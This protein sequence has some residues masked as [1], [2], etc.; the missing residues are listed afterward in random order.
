MTKFTG[1]IHPAA[2]MFPLL[3][4]KAFEEFCDDIEK[5][6]LSKPIEL[7]P[8]GRLIDGRNRLRACQEIR[9]E[10]EF[11]TVNPESP[12]AY[13][14]S[15]N[16]HRRHL[17]SSQLAALAVEELPRL[18][19]QAKERQRKGKKKVADPSEVGQSRH[20]AAKLFNTNSH[21]VESAERIKRDAPD[22]FEKLKSGEV[23][24]PAALME[25]AKRTGK[26]AEL[27]ANAAKTRAADFV[28]RIAGVRGY[29]EKVSVDAIRSDERLRRQWNETLKDA[30]SALRDLQKRLGAKEE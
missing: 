20:H 19:D 7:L 14:L 28:G 8:D 26:R 23:A 22:V 15:A 10:P 24:M 27:V 16:K 6:G 11:V 2:E 5:H 4:G 29:C 9:I 25:T 3:E 18:R 17:T 30:I 1:E 21:Y 13:V 12:V